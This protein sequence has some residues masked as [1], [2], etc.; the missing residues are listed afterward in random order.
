MTEAIAGFQR[1]RSANDRRGGCP[2]CA[3]GCV[4]ACGEAGRNRAAQFWPAC[5]HDERTGSSARHRAPA[6]ISQSSLLP[7]HAST[8]A[9]T[10]SRSELPLTTRH[11]LLWTLERR[12]FRGASDGC[13]EQRVGAG[14]KR[15]R[16]KPVLCRRSEA[17]CT[18]CR[19]AGGYEQRGRSQEARQ[20]AGGRR[21]RQRRRRWRRRRLGN[22]AGACRSVPGANRQACAGGSCTS[23]RILAT[24]KRPA[25][26]LPPPSPTLTSLALRPRRSSMRCRRVHTGGT[27]PRMPVLACASLTLCCPMRACLQPF[28]LPV[29]PL[30]Q[31]AFLQEFYQ[32]SLSKKT[33][34]VWVQAGGCWVV[35]RRRCC[36]CWALPAVL[37][38]HHFRQRPLPPAARRRR[39]TSAST[40]LAHQTLPACL[41]TARH[42]PS[43]LEPLRPLPASHAP[44]CLAPPPPPPPAPRR[45][46]G[47]SA[48]TSASP[49]P[50]AAS[51]A[52]SSSAWRG[53]ATGGQGRGGWEGVGAVDAAGAWWGSSRFVGRSSPRSLVVSLLLRAGIAR[54]P[55]QK[56]CAASACRCRLTLAPVAIH[57]PTHASQVCRGDA[58]CDKGGTRHE[59]TGVKRLL[60]CSARGS[61]GIGGS[62]CSDA[63]IRCVYAVCAA[64]AVLA[65]LVQLAAR[66]SDHLLLGH[67]ASLLHL[68]IYVCLS[69]QRNPAP[70]SGP[71]NRC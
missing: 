66:G 2:T 33:R 26:I 15:L 21:R 70:S 59:R 51:A 57:P 30:L 14:R 16:P 18:L 38:L 53:V 50:A 39:G 17:P 24:P 13:G 67:A 62:G 34:A 52:A 64:T 68:Y 3:Q 5:R 69:F 58:D 4:Q 37:P 49:S 63:A 36:G 60:A 61:G 6:A 28:R 29:P 1:L 12:A 42:D 22:V 31:I 41:P 25:P 56:S 8:H 54:Q 71:P 10:A 45:R 19:H 9:H 35:K 65:A 47:T 55:Q 27:G 46:C 23:M 44:A 11:G 32:V 48:L 7:T 43:L 20:V 40:G